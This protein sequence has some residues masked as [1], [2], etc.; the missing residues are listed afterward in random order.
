MPHNSRIDVRS[1]CRLSDRLFITVIHEWCF[2][3]NVLDELICC[4]SSDY[5]GQMNRSQKVC[6][7]DFCQHVSRTQRCC[8]HFIT[9]ADDQRPKRTL[10]RESSWTRDRAGV[11]SWEGAGQATRILW[12]YTRP[13]EGSVSMAEVTFSLLQVNASLNSFKTHHFRV[14]KLH[15]LS[16]PQRFLLIISRHVKVCSNIWQAKKMLDS[17]SEQRQEAADDFKAALSVIMKKNMSG[18]RAIF[19]RLYNS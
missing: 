4:L 5:F 14:E 13:A 15:L 11:F 19:L 18:V 12:P 7:S 3:V 8:C 10:R 1:D 6:K 17:E 2:Q 16:H 9:A